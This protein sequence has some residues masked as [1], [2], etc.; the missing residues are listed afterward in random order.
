MAPQNG[1]VHAQNPG[2]QFQRKPSPKEELVMVDHTSGDFRHDESKDQKSK[3]S[4]NAKI[5]ERRPHTPLPPIVHASSKTVD[6]SR[7]S[8]Q[9]ITS[10]LQAPMLT[11][12]TTAR[13]KR[14]AKATTVQT[15]EIIDDKEKENRVSVS[16][17][18]AQMPSDS[19]KRRLDSAA[20]NTAFS[21]HVDVPRLPPLTTQ[22]TV[23]TLAVTGQKCLILAYI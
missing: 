22:S 3:T 14:R 6:P 19:S 20:F 16:H 10:F 15:T 7:K 9:A 1:N 23:S 18:S 17:I 5:Q 11:A 12:E 4:L 21:R 8:P 13:R 2:V